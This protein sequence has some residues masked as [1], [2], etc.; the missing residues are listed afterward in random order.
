MFLRLVFA[1]RR[2]G[3]TLVSLAHLCLN[4]LFSRQLQK[5]N[6]KDLKL[7]NEVMSESGSVSLKIKTLPRR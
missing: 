2:I 7:S 4:G 1:V 5:P 3:E 6:S